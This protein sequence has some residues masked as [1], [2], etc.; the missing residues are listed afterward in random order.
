MWVAPALAL[1][2]LAGCGGDKTVAAGQPAAEMREY[3]GRILAVETY[4]EPDIDYDSMSPEQLTAANRSFA[5]QFLP[6]ADQV[7][8]AA[9][10]Q[11]R[12]DTEILVSAV[13]QVTET[14]DF[15][16]AFESPAANDRRRA[17][18][19]STSRTASGPRW[20]WSPRS[21]PS[22]ASRRR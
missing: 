16:A 10:A 12:A 22:R 5:A 19:P 13:R 4:P 14:G 2:A 8:A 20:T 17:P 6:L 21:T 3:C 7:L 18:T 1:G 9:P 11:V 15:E